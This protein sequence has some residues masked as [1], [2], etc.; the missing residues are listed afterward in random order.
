MKVYIYCDSCKEETEHILIRQDKHLYKCK[1]CGSVT[2]YLP[3]KEFDVKAIISSGATSEVGKV[4]LKESDIVKIGDEV[5]V[6]TDEG[7]KVG[8]VTAI[9][10][11]D[12]KR[13]VQIA[14]A[15]DIYAVWLRNVSEVDVKFSLHKGP[16]TTPYKLKT[17]GET[18]FEVGE[19][20][21]I[22][23]LLFRIT[24]IKTIDGRLL[25]KERDKAKAKE[26]KRIYA[27]FV[28][29]LR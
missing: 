19:K 14:D 18:E 24:R 27:M 20:I 5:I 23:G 2:Q 7:F 10:L 13:R 6:E 16:V 22:D 26:I 8:E 3:E 12:R 17:S 9:E 29:K 15:K 4:R 1:E 11:R 28:K 21:N 25:R